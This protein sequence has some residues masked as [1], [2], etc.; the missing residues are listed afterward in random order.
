MKNLLSFLI[1]FSFFSCNDN[2]LTP[3]TSF[4]NKMAIYI[5]KEGQL[6]MTG[7]ETN[8]DLNSLNL[9]SSP[10]LKSSDIELYD[11]SSHTFYLNTNKEKG[12]YSGRHFVVA[13]GDERLFLGV[14]FPIYMSSIPQIPSI[15]A[16]DDFIT[17][18]D[19]IQFGQLGHKF[20]GEINKT[21]NF[22]QALDSSG[23]LHNGIEVELVNLKKKNNTTVDYTFKVTNLDSETLYLLDPDKMGNSRFHY[24]TNGVNF[25]QNETYYFPENIQHT[26]FETVPESWYIKLRPGQNMVRTVELSGF[27]NLSEGTVKCWF[28]FPGSII[29]AGEWKK[30]DGRIW[31]GNYFVEKE[32]ELR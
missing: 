16:M 20:T 31:M 7:S 23:I 11:W 26:S 6:Q 17:P 9:D 10:W 22:K 5:V 13:S 30:R 3:N 29:K 25:V 1:L 24:V 19:I 18:N 21:D 8:I 28:S 15:M 32:I 12:K 27:S 2:D 4:D 14:F